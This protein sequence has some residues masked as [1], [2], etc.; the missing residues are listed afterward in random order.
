MYRDCSPTRPL[1][2]GV[3]LA[4]TFFGFLLLIGLAVIAAA[5]LFQ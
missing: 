5:L 2:D 1:A 4:W 3:I